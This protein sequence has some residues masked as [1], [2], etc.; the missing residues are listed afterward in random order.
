MAKTTEKNNV[1]SSEW[2]FSYFSVDIL[3]RKYISEKYSENYSE[4]DWER[5]LKE[6]NI[7]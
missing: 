1:Y 7:L 3:Y 4:S 6:E 5:I 2:A